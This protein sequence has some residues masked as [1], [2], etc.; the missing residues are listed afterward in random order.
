L[1]FYVGGVIVIGW[2]VPHNDPRLL[3]A[4]TA[5]SSP[6]VIAIQNAKIKA[7]PSII[8]AVILTQLSRPGTP[9]YMHPRVPCMALHVPAKHRI[10]PQ[11]HE[12]GFTHLV[13]LH[14]M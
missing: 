9:F 3:G 10:S 13:C 2:L 11:V 4:S 8:N 6:F 1:F 5:A 12:G 7:L 14:H